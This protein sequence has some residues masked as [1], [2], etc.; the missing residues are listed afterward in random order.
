MVRPFICAKITCEALQFGVGLL[1][2]HEGAT[3]GPGC[4]QLGRYFF[5]EQRGDLVYTFFFLFPMIFLALALRSSNMRVPA[6]SSTMPKNF[7]RT[8]I[9]HLLSNENDRGRVKTGT[10]FGDTALHDQE[11]WG[12]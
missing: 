11:S 8:H 6:A 12:H 2:L 4:I 10:N 1:L 9:E 3:L 5:G 7:F